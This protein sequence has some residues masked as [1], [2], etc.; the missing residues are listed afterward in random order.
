[1]LLMVLRCITFMHTPLFFPY[2]IS[3]A[4]PV[5]IYLNLINISDSG[6]LFSSVE[7][8]EIE[9]LCIRS[10]TKMAAM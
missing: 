5:G 3:D 2:G 6:S 8:Q 7:L 1:M 9:I 10:N 4:I